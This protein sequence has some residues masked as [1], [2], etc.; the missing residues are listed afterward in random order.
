MTSKDS[1]EKVEEKPEEKKVIE[2]PKK[3][4]PILMKKGDYTVHVFIEEVKN[5][6]S[7]NPDFLPKTVVKVQCFNQS[8]RTS[9]VL[10]PCSE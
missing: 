7:V 9:K 3:Q 10:E 5:L 4:T 6:I 1:E 2:P 8:K